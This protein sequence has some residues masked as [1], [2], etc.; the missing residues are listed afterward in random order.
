VSRKDDKRVDARGKLLEE[1]FRVQLTRD[2]ALVYWQGRIVRTLTGAHAEVV[3]AA[4]RAGDEGALQLLLAR[5]TGN[6]KRGNER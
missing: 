4:I 2:K 1:P 3:R 6:F 5:L